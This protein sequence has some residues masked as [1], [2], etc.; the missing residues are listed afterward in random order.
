MA[1][2]RFLPAA[3]LGRRG[4]ALMNLAGHF[5]RNAAMAAKIFRGSRSA[6]A[7][8]LQERAAARKNFQGVPIETPDRPERRHSTRSSA[9]IGDQL[10]G[11]LSEPAIGSLT[12]KTDPWGSRAEAQSRPPWDSMILRQI[13]N[14]IPVR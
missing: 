2:L 12:K 8:G 4:Y 7:C 13:A 9:G 11:L 14:P 10:R 6:L 5:S 3:S 1:T